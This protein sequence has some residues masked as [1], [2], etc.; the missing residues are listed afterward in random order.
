[1][2]ILLVSRKKSDATNLRH[3]LK[4]FPDHEVTVKHRLDL[5]DILAGKHLHDILIL[6]ESIGKNLHTEDV[7]LIQ[8]SS[9]FPA[10]VLLMDSVSLAQKVGL[11]KSGYS[12][13]LLRSEMIEDDFVLFLSEV[14]SFALNHTRQIKEASKYKLILNL[15]GEGTGIIDENANITFANPMLEKMFGE[16]PGGLIGR[17]FNDFLVV[18]S[19]SSVMKPKLQSGYD[20][21]GTYEINM[22]GKGEEDNHFLITATPWED[23][24][25]DLRGSVVVVRDVTDQVRTNRKVR[26]NEVLYR[27]LAR[28]IPQAAVFL[29]DKS[30]T[31]SLAEGALLPNLGFNSSRLIGKR[32]EKVFEK[33]AFKLLK[34]LFKSSV[35]GRVAKVK[36]FYKGQIY[37]ISALPV[38]NDVDEIIGGMTVV[39]DVSDYEEIQNAL[40]VANREWERTFDLVPDIVAVFDNKLRVVRANKAMCERLGKRLEEIIGHSCHNGSEA[41]DCSRLFSLGETVLKEAKTVEKIIEIPS[42]DAIFN[43]TAVPM[44]DDNNKVE[45]VIHVAR[46][47]TETRRAEVKLKQS[48]ERLQHLLTTAPAVLYTL[49]ISEPRYVSFVS[50][51]IGRIFGHDPEKFREDFDYFYSLVHPDDRNKLHGELQKLP[52]ERE[53]KKEYR[54]KNQNGEYIWI[55]DQMRVLLDDKG[56]P[57]EMVG[58]MADITE[59]QKV[60][61]ALEASEAKLK[62][63]LNNS[64]QGFMLLDNNYHLLVLNKIAAEYSKRL[65]GQVP[66]KNKS[67]LL[68]LPRVERV[69]LEKRLQTC[70]AGIIVSYERALVDMDGTRYWFEI[71]LIPVY[72]KK[73]K[74]EEVLLS[75]MEISDRKE[76]LELLERSE[77]RFRSLVQN[78]SDI[79]SILNENGRIIYQTPAGEE[80]FGLSINEMYEK[81]LTEFIHEEDRDNVVREFR[82]LVKTIGA[83][84]SLEFRVK[85]AKGGYDYLDAIMNNR[86]DDPNINGVVV[87]SRNISERRKSEEQIRLLA[88]AIE[89]AGEAVL[90]TDTGD[91]TSDPRVVFVNDAFTKMTGYSPGEVIAK[92]PSF[93]HG[94]KTDVDIIDKIKTEALQGITFSAETVNYKKSGEEYIVEWT[95]SPVRDKIGN[96]TQVVSIQSD[97]TERKKGERELKKSA[98]KLSQQNK[99]LEL[100]RRE[101]E[102][103]REAVERAAGELRLAYEDAAGARKAAES[104]SEAKSEFLANMSH[105]I[106][107]PM[108]AVL[109]FAKLFKETTADQ[110][111]TEF[112]EQ[113]VSSGEH[114]LDLINDVLDLS[115]VEAGQLQIEPEPFNLRKLVGEIV[116]LYTPLAV[117]KGLRV[118]C[119][120]RDLPQ[121]EV[122]DQNRIRQILSN[123][124]S[125][126]IKYT[127]DGY[128]SLVVKK[129]DDGKGVKID[130]QDT[131]VGI[132]E[133]HQAQVFEP[134]FQVKETGLSP[135]A[136]SGLGLAISARLVK[137]MGGSLEMNS[138]LGKGTTFE[139]SIPCEFVEEKAVKEKIEKISA[140]KKREEVRGL[141]I[142]AADDHAANRKLIEH[143]L[144]GKGHEVRLA[145][146]GEVAVDLF[147]KE[148]F[149][150]VILDVQMPVMNGYEA[151][152]KIR[153][154]PGGNRIPVLTLTAYAMRGDRERAISA[155]AD[156]YLSKPFD[157][158]ELASVVHSLAKKGVKVKMTTTTIDPELDSLR[159]E[160]LEDL[161]NKAETFVGELPE[162]NELKIWA[163]K[164]AGTGGSF[165]YPDITSLGRIIEQSLEEDEDDRSWITNMLTRLIRLGQESLRALKKENN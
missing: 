102:K 130:I 61:K 111:S 161:I 4:N 143:V 38:M 50:D 164:I 82:R 159:T 113:I 43:V 18:K 146:N 134:F 116:D 126:A 118:I 3:L 19:S 88:T 48:E 78:S 117:S 90:I 119:K 58:F 9:G 71:Q 51:N 47:I 70:F 42:L 108:T 55:R 63:I 104:A 30:L 162:M 138:E 160:Y 83:I 64:L 46:D 98:I 7:Q 31:C 137:A 73:G 1:M 155:G 141:K 75:F 81:D 57:R 56:Y 5:G 85:N 112:V 142:L 91:K 20:N 153:A 115:K 41:E 29:Y 145:E 154:L 44:L 124:L 148:A 14:R 128:V 131:G 49:R 165:G 76:A 45:G 59:S 80:S 121:Y 21:R 123:L 23:E 25:R 34:P 28:N 101:A 87:T 62:A 95:I 74:V 54:I 139:I 65:V 129:S 163:H 125:N 79:I 94:V 89:T 12:S 27:L 122:L 132:N 107:T 99:Q 22:K 149:D 77:Q 37:Q 40:K 72:D 110:E 147:R 36:Q 60:E 106:R 109:G 156:E 151:I 103:A 136:G 97:I 84:T 17:N 133:S 15:Q 16:S 8:T 120:F 33:E 105:E 13:L 10:L 152:R 11:M 158:Q 52:P 24:D 127:E 67:V 114:L 96:I 32:L 2:K 26:E 39:L 144:V 93:L 100:A 86:L 69:D 92:P 150:V 35:I 68:M 140:I 6:D 135:Q 53:L 157:P 66:V